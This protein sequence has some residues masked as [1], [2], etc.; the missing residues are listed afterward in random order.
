MTSQ[1]QR[2][3]ELLKLSGINSKAQVREI[4][5]ELVKKIEGEK[6]GTTT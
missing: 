1:L 3:I 5:T 4:L 6:D 2:C